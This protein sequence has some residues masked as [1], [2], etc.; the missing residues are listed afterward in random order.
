ME[1]ASKSNDENGNESTGASFSA[2]EMDRSLTVKSQFGE[3]PVNSSA[4]DASSERR[5]KKASTATLYGMA[6][7]VSASGPTRFPSIGSMLGPYFCLG[8]L[9]KGTFS[10][11]H[12]CINMQYFHNTNDMND[13]NRKPSSSSASSSSAVLSR[14]QARVAA[15]KVELGEFSQSGILDSEAAVLDFLHR[16]LPSGTVPIYMGHYRTS[17]VSSDDERYAQALFMEYLPGP[18]MH[19]LREKVMAKTKQQVLYQQ[20]QQQQSKTPPTHQYATRRIATADAVFLTANVLLPLLQRLHGVGVVHRDVKPSNCVRSSVKD[21]DKSFC[22]VDFGLSKSII[23]PQS[24]EYADRDH[25]WE[26]PWL[27]PLH[28]SGGAYRKERAKADFRGTSMYASLRVHQGR[29]YCPRDDIWS[30]LYVFCDLVS[31]GLPWMSNAA[32]RDRAGCQ[33]LKERVHG[34]KDSAEAKDET[35]L[36]LMG[37]EYHTAAYKRNRQQAAGWEEGKLTVLPEP[38]AL[39]RDEHKVGLL[40]R[41][42]HHVAR[43]QFYDMPDYDLIQQCILGFGKSETSDP[44]IA[45]IKWNRAFTSP[46]LKRRNLGHPE[47]DLLDLEDADPLDE[48]AFRDAQTEHSLSRASSMIRRLP[49]DFQFY[50]AQMK[51]DAGDTP[52]HRALNDWMQVV[53]RLLYKEWDARKYEDGGHRTSTDGFRRDGYLSL[54]QE[55]QACAAKHD[56]FRSRDCYYTQDVRSGVN[57]SASPALG[58]TPKRRRIT[59]HGVPSSEKGTALVFVSKAIFGLERAIVL[60]KA[61]KPPPPMRISFS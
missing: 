26:G 23:V 48:E 30:L 38:L 25:L 1:E 60:E 39:S 13:D 19:Q 15:A 2:V 4:P 12:K 18:D 34:L 8:R 10:T 50:I 29:D 31:G 52:P 36:L 43:L 32:N 35:A 55:C 37:D 49:V 56:F 9:G 40:R 58:P 41:A 5:R 28:S 51:Q 46:M 11:I 14:Q 59:I 33:A 54:L 22:L 16:S 17:V 44:P 24:L 45:P 61:K 3:T 42:F 21:N 57:G 47:W 7:T 53:T 20:Q 27:K 6:T